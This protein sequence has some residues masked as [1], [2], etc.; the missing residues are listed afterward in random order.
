LVEAHCF[1]SRER[2]RESSKNDGG[3]EKFTGYFMHLGPK[4]FYYSTLP[5]HEISW[6]L[7][8]RGCLEE[9]SVIMAIQ[10][11]RRALSQSLTLKGFVKRKQKRNECT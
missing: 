3:N 9:E 7:S 1:C 2:E 10:Y 6:S 11:S 5:G 8:E 4:I